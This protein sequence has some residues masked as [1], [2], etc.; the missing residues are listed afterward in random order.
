[1]AGQ[2]GSTQGRSGSREPGRVAGILAPGMAEG[3][4]SGV[5]IGP[6]PVRL[7]PPETTVGHPVQGGSRLPG[8]WLGPLE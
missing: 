7:A 8:G 3:R 4:A 2:G 5:D 6:F 1:L